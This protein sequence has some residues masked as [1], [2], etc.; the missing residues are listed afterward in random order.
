MEKDDKK[1]K[2]YGISLLRII[3]SFMVA[4]DHFYDLKKKQKFVNILYYHIPTFFLISFYYNSKNLIS[5]D[6]KK[7]KLRFKRLIFPFF[8]WTV[9]SFLLNNIYYYQFKRNCA[10]TFSDF[11]RGLLCGRNFIVALWFQIVLI[12]ITLILTL[13]ILLF[14]ND[15]LLIFQI[16]MIISYRFQYSGENYRFFFKH[17]DKMYAY[18]YGRV[19]DVFPHSIT[20]FFIS[21]MK[22]KNRIIYYKIRTILISIFILFIITKY[23]FDNSLLTFKYGGIRQNIASCCI[24]FLFLLSFENLKNNKI[25]KIIDILSNYTAG[26]YF[27]HLLIGNSYLVRF[28]LA[29]KINTIYG[30]FNI[31]IISYIICFLIDNSFKSITIKYLIK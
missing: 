14:K 4:I 12:F 25:K 16:L 6:I 10:H 13:L 23:N 20:G 29:K 2:D 31:Y 22:I 15:Y 24:F 28:L 9:F 17:Y 7:N 11:L 26:I 18:T 8:F 5:F 3:L 27:I 1:K 30:C 21:S 19:I